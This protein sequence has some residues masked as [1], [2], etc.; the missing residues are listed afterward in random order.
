MDSP[1]VVE[2]YKKLQMVEVAI[3]NLKTV[4][5]EV[6]PVFHKT[7]ERI[8]AH[9]F[10]CMLA[11]HVQWHMKTRLQPLFDEDGKGKCREWTFVNIIERLKAIRR[12][13][14]VTA[15]SSF[16]QT[17]IPADDQQRILDLLKI[18]L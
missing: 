3:R 8:R 14:R 5:L 7:D 10:L 11:D 1:K 6:R 13:K 17:T 4:L 12:D 15:D 16:F 18:K 9:V 2:S